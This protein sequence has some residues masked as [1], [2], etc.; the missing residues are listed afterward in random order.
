MKSKLIILN[1]NLTE[2][3]HEETQQTIMNM[4]MILRKMDILTIVTVPMIMTT[5]K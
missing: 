1:M 5:R 2:R 4:S 3:P